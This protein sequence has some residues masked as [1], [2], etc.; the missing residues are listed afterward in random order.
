M[1][2]GGKAH[3]Y[4]ERQH[5]HGLGVFSMFVF[6]RIAFLT[7]C[8]SLFAV[9]VDKSKRKK[10]HEKICHCFAFVALTWATLFK[11]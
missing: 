6:V 4:S 2:D 5:E 11:C 7:R 10:K 3:P 8:L 1:L 9:Q